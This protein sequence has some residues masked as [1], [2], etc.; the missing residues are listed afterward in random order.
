MG[1]AP[2]LGRIGAVF[3]QDAPKTWLEIQLVDLSEFSGCKD[4]LTTLQI[5][6][7]A[8]V[9]LSEYHFLKLTEMMLFFQRFKAGRYGKFYGAVDSLVITTALISFISERK[10]DIQAFE[11]E[12]RR[13]ARQIEEQKRKN[14][15]TVSYADY[16]KLKQIGYSQDDFKEMYINRD[17]AIAAL[18]KIR[19]HE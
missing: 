3:G 14:I 18:N 17:A 1:K 5:R 10:E 15:V 6:Q 19:H 8:E 9:I 13:E 4:K 12:E 16:Q 7:T 11:D 2:S